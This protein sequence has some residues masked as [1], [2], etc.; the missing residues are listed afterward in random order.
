MKKLTFFVFFIFFSLFLLILPQQIYA[1]QEVLDLTSKVQTI[2]NYAMGIGGVI[3]FILIIVGA[4]Q[5]ILSAGNPDRVKAGKEM[6]TSAMAGLFLVV[7]AVLILR[8]VGVDI[9]QIP[10]FER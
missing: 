1:D 9:L 2:V 10:G 6:I 3:A 5:I 8:I 4:F 7:F